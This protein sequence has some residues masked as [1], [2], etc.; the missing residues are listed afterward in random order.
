MTTNLDIIKRAMRKLHVLGTGMEPSSAQAAQAMG[1]LS[2]LYVE[3]IGM[4]SL[5]RLYDVQATSDADGLEWTR[6]KASNGV[7]IT[8]PLLITASM[9]PSYPG[10]YPGSGGPDYGWWPS[11]WD[12]FPR[13]PFDMAPVVI[14]GSNYEVDG[15]AFT[16]ETYWLYSAYK[17]EWMQV[18]SLTQQD[19]F[20]LP[21]HFENG[22]AAWLAEYMADDFGS[23]EVGPDTRIQARNCRVM[24]TCRFDSPSRP[25]VTNYF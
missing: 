8:L 22:F 17:G 16:S 20:P 1:N 21:M 15:N 18:I 7:D 25:V 6:I 2:S 23:M 19:T 4:G 14:S 5:G 12:N 24:L 11:G 3:M 10:Y 9:A 13:T